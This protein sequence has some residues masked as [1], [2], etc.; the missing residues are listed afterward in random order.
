MSSKVR[1]SDEE[2]RTVITPLLLSGAKMLDRHCPVCGAPLFE[3]DGKVFCPVC[4]RRKEMGTTEKASN[5]VNESEDEVFKQLM[6]KLEELA[7]S[8]PSDLDDLERHLRVM[9]KIL[10]V[11][12]RYVE[13]KTNM[14]DERYEGG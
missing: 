12:E 2:I 1:L 8:M 4:E 6:G 11:V 7:S 9:E 5:T 14:G 13:L 10:D 3:K